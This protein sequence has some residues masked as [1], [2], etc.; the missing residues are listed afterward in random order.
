MVMN[1]MSDIIIMSDI[2]IHK[3]QAQTVYIVRHYST[4]AEMEIRQIS[5]G[6]RD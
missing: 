5:L 1:I 6:L 3:K 2:C 4:P